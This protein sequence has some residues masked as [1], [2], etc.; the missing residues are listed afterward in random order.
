MPNKPILFGGRNFIPEE[1]DYSTTVMTDISGKLSK[2][3]LNIDAA[4]QRLQQ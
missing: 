3:A 2:F 1:F 4:F